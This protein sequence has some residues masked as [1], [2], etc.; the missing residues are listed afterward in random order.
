MKKINFSFKT[1][2]SSE[3]YKPSMKWL[4]YGH[5]G[6]IG[7]QI[8][9]YLKAHLSSETIL[10]TP[11]RVDD[12][13]A[14]EREISRLEPDRVLC[15]I[16]RTHGEGFSTIDY[17]EQRGKIAE[18]VRDN[19]YGPLSLA[20]ICQKRGIHLTYMGTGCIFTYDE[21]HTSDNDLG[22]TEDDLPNYFDSGYS[23]VKGYT[24]RL[25]HFFPETVLNVRI[26]MPITSQDHHRNFI[27]KIVRYEKVCSN[28][29]SM[30]VLDELVPVLVD[31]VKRGSTGTINLT[32][33]GRIT[34]N[35]ILDLYQEL[36]DPDFTYQNFSVEEQSK[37][38]KCGRSNNLLDTTRLEREYPQVKPIEEAI[39]EVLKNW[40]RATRDDLQ[41]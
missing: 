5:A 35:R 16:G 26:R 33:P 27:S 23:V 31:L 41:E 13:E 20:M 2:D 40:K 30:T 6:W 10:T 17:L 9:S 21:S 4:I 12:T 32:N 14:V 7:Q 19:L 25:M 24:D 11:T 22:F 39:I 1:K 3:K 34:H 28:P 8:V 15:L 38:L 37:I 36:V 18:N 29:N